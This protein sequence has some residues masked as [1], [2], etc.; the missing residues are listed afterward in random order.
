[1]LAPRARRHLIQLPHVRAVLWNIYGTLLAIS[2]GELLFEHPNAFI[3]DTALDKTIQEFNMWG[4][5]SRKPGQPS[6]YMKSIYREVLQDLMIRAPRNSPEI[7]TER[8]WEAIVKKL[9]QKGYKFDSNFYGALNEYSAKVAYFFH[10]SLQGTACYAGAANA[11]KQVANR[12][13]V[14]GLL[15]DGQCFTTVQLQRGLKQQDAD[16]D[17]DA[18]IDPRLRLLSCQVGLR[19]PSE[20]LF[21][22]ALEKLEERGIAPVQVLH[23]GSR[24]TQDIV[25]AKKLGMRTA[26]FAGDSSSLQAT[27]EQL[28]ASATRPDIL[29]TSLEQ[30][31]ELFP[32]E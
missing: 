29:L 15:A 20:A 21:Q 12:Q 1:V 6:D 18:L 23:I 28:K 10:A 19:K 26:L 13:L 9:L 8:I 31:A 11:L 24:L 3:M 2:G 4:S 5:M 7:C 25:P 16:V 22:L 32:I 17:L 30:I 14:Q 27:P